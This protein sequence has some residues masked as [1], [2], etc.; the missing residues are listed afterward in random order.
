MPS[1]P[2]DKA[3][4]EPNH[5]MVAS[6]P[7]ILCYLHSF[8]E[9]GVERVALRLCTAWSRAGGRVR[10]LIGR[11]EAA[12]RLTRPAVHCVRFSSFGIPTRRFE[13]LWMIL[14]L[15]RQVRA[16]RPDVIFCAG[17][18]YAIVA[19]ALRLLLGRACP[20]VLVKISNS[21]E[22]RDMPAPVRLCYRLWL[23]IQGRLLHHFVAMAPAMRGEAAAALGIAASRLSVVEN[24]AITQ[25]QLSALAAPDR[26]V[27]RSPRRVLSVGRLVRQK[28]FDLLIRAFSRAAGPHDTLVIV[29][30]GPRRAALQRLI[31]R[32]GL[33][34]RVRLAGHDPDVAPYFRDADLFVLSSDYEGLPSVLVE[35]LA[36]GIAIV[37]T[38]CSPAISD[39]L[40]HGR[41]GDV[42]AV[43]DE[44]WLARAIAAAPSLSPSPALASA[45]AVRHLLE[46]AAP[47]Y[48]DLLRR[49]AAGGEE[50]DPAI[51]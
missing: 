32:L 40:E 17:N 14:C 48:L 31:D 22:R 51:D 2:S 37:A 29:G 21:V 25:Q 41:L 7:L 15:W 9:G 26:V 49:V 5:A 33:A 47:A 43:G 8:A 28:R 50:K 23:R 42:V 45:R 38:D 35:A 16:E 6:D 46:R 19:V 3:T 24:P 10:V 39:L 13:T 20:P 18:T 12:D 27:P 30:D 4:R 11:E 44:E 1:W 34:G 36:A